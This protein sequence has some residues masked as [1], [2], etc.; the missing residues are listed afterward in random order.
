MT[1]EETTV[2]E[3]INA[4]PEISEKPKKPK[5][6]KGKII[7]LVVVI[8]VVLIFGGGGVAYGTQHSNPSF[9][10]FICHTPM[11]PYVESY[12]N[13]VSVNAAEADITGPEGALLNVTVHK[14]AEDSVVC[15]D[16]HNDGIDAQIA[17]GMA[18]VS[19]DYTVPLEG[20][21]LV[22]TDKPK[23]G[24]VSGVTFC[25]REGCHTSTT[26][27]ELKANTTDVTANG[28]PVHDGHHGYVNC[29]LCHQTHEQSV[30]LCAKPGCHS[31]VTLPEGWAKVK[32]TS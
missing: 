19:G 21:K 14:N 9:C 16:C 24:E 10:N 8:V 25:L 20:F 26:L 32:A 27:E 7:L 15:V 28:Q 11:D 17:E 18:W 6:G 22:S 12:H 31:N 1:N 30:L 29:S 4:E 5:G 13:N 3:E 23:D 2:I